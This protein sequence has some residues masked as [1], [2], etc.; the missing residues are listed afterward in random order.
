MLSKVEF[1]EIDVFSTLEKAHLS[2]IVSELV[3]NRWSGFD[4]SQRQNM[5]YWRA[6]MK[7]MDIGC[8]QWRHGRGLSLYSA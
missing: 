8:V 4:A 6:F 5:D 2:R 3:K 7:T 1:A